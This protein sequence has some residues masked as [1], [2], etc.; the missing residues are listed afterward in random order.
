M[1]KYV[2][3]RIEVKPLHRASLK[4]AVDLK[5]WSKGMLEG[6]SV[7]VCDE[8]QIRGRWVYKDR[9][10]IEN[11]SEDTLELEPRTV[12]A[13]MVAPFTIDFE[14]SLLRADKAG[15][16]KLLLDVFARISDV[17]IYTEDL[18]ID[19][20]E[21]NKA[22]CSKY[23]KNLLAEMGLKE[24]LH[25]K[26]LV[27]NAQFKLLDED[28]REKML[29]KYRDQLKAL[30]FVIKDEFSVYKVKLSS[31]GT[32]SYE[33]DAPPATLQ[34]LEDMM[35]AF[36][37]PDVAVLVADVVDAHNEQRERE[38]KSRAAKKKGGK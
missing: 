11:Y 24:V 4:M 29:D 12:E 6:F 33:E 34:I 25:D 31:K 37:D 36:H 28:Q 14:R 26:V 15:D 23:K 30:H 10:A 9:Y 27:T 5:G 8:R 20:Y 16:V 38:A 18:A 21:L 22:F 13:R 7:G 2:Y 17:D 3:K 32:I 35:M 19:L 1:N